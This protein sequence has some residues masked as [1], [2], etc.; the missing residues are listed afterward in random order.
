MAAGREAVSLRVA[1]MALRGVVRVLS[2]DLPADG[3][4]GIGRAAVARRRH[5][6]REP[7]DDWSRRKES[8]R[9]REPPTATPST[10]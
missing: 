8:G 1:A 9:V 5:R 10:R 7:R 3:D 6:A 2:K 4:L